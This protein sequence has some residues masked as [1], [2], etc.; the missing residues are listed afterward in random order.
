MRTLTITLTAVILAALCITTLDPFLNALERG[1]PA[2]T[3]CAAGVLTGAALAL[4]AVCARRD[5]G[6]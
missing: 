6:I 2:A 3:V 5:G 4:C 1:D